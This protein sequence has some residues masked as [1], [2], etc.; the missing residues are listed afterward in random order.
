MTEKIAVLAP[1]PSAS[2]STAAAKKPGAWKM[3][4]QA[5]RKSAASDASIRHLR[6]V[7]RYTVD[8][9]TGADAQG[10]EKPLCY[11]RSSMAK[12][13]IGL[14]TGVLLVFLTFVLLFFAL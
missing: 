4:R 8:A 2:A 9:R 6:P 13:F 5:Y 12:F 14:V 1:M 10:E 7:L 11:F 3:D